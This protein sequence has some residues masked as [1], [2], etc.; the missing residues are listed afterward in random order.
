MQCLSFKPS[1]PPTSPQTQT[2]DLNS[3]PPASQ[4]DSSEGTPRS[5]TQPSPTFNLS[6][7]YTLAV[8]TNSY[9]EMRSRIEERVQVEDVLENGDTHHLILSQ[10][11]Q[12][13]RDCVAQALRHTNP[14]ATLTRL[15]STYFEHSENITDLCLLLCQC[16]DRA[17]TLYSPITELLQVFPYELNSISQ[18]QCNWAFD[19]FQQFYSLDNPFPRPDSHNFNEM[20]CSFSQLK[21]QLDHRINKSHSRVRFLHRAT[22]GSAICLIGT[23]VGVVVSAVVISTNALASIVGLVATPLCLVYVPTDLRRKQLAH[24]AQLDVAKKGTSVHNYDLDTIDRLVA[25]LYTSVEA[26]RQLIRFGLE[27]DRDIYPIHEVVKH[28][29][30][31]HDNFLDQLKELEEHICLCFNSVNKFRAKLLDQIHHH[32]S[33]YS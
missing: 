7:E 9:N 8:Q 23:V 15:V 28:L 30:G 1:P 20:R 4:G 26:D 21:E 16:V 12:P 25:L 18:A 27:R 14:K 32:Q 13:N 19:V 3:C 10:M 17:R 24:M 6:R 29:R 22:T 33:T 5:S 11:L 2:I 31:S